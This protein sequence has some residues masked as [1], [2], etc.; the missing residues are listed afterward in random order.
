MIKKIAIISLGLL[1]LLAFAQP[2]VPTVT[3]LSSYAGITGTIDKLA[4]WMLGI[5]VAVATVFFIYA[6]FLYLVGAGDEEKLGAA[7]NY[8]IYAVI[9][10]AVGLLSKTI[11]A[12]LQSFLGT[13]V[14]P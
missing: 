14:A 10:I 7:K 2:T 6:G 4:N 5:L 1:P 3:G 8:I 13:T 11:T 12:F 9:A